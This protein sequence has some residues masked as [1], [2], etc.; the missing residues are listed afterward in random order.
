MIYYILTC[1]YIGLQTLFGFSHFFSHYLVPAS[2]ILHPPSGCFSGSPL[3]PSI[4][5]HISSILPPCRSPPLPAAVTPYPTYRLLLS[6]H[7]RPLSVFLGNASPSPWDEQTQPASPTPW[8]AHGRKY[9]ACRPLLYE[10]RPMTPD[11][12]KHS[13]F[14]MQAPVPEATSSPS[15]RASVT[16]KQRTSCSTRASLS[17][18]NISGTSG[19]HK[20]RLSK[21]SCQKDEALARGLF[22]TNISH[23]QSN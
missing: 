15:S 2:L 19:L 16:E 6:G 13:N 9:T 11:C 18:S 21:R 20:P 14:K 12:A 4:L 1:L 8:L 22:S 10:G 17:N 5:L 23:C 7:S 3:L